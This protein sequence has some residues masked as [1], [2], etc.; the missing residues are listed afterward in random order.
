MDFNFE[1][2]DFTKF[3]NKLESD[4]IKEIPTYDKT[5]TETYRI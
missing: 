4:I 5:S 3:S 1:E 2:I